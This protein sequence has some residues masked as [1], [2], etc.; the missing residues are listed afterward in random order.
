LHGFLGLSGYYRHF[1]QEYAKIVTPLTTLLQKNIPYVW[2]VEADT[3]FH[4]LKEALTTAPILILP[5]FS[6]SFTIETDA[7]GIRIGVITLLPT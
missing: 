3:T 5:D 4:R 2:G 7:S 1:I 6:Q